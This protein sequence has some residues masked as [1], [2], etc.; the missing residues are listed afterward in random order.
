MLKNL[1]R[2]QIKPQILKVH[3]ISQFCK[4]EQKTQIN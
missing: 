2:V 4:F 3:W 1:N